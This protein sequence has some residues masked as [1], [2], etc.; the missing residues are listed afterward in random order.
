MFFN[1]AVQSV[2]EILEGCFEFVDAAE[3]VWDGE[4]V[5]FSFEVFGEVVPLYFSPVVP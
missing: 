2:F 4:F 1:D 3:G 5:E